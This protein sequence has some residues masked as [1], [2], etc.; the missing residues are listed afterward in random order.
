M[1]GQKQGVIS[2]ILWSVEKDVVLSLPKLFE[3]PAVF[4]ES[5]QIFS[6][7]RFDQQISSGND[8]SRM[9]RRHL[10]GSSCL[11]NQCSQENI[12]QNYLRRSQVGIAH[13]STLQ[14]HGCPG[15][16]RVVCSV[17]ISKEVLRRLMQV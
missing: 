4:L 10:I 16:R 15:I 17:W 3:N 13:A 11:S 5:W 8:I 12:Y 14:Q 7:G 6:L 9:I 2:S 1:Q